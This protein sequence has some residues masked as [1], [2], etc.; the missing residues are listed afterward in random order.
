MSDPKLISPMLDNFDMGAP[1]TDRMGIRCCPAMKKDADDKY[2]VKI[3][4]IPAS[5]VQLDALLLTGA[6]ADEASAQ[7]Y[8]KELSDTVAEEVRILN[9]LSQ[10]EGFLPYEDT[11]TVP[12]DDQTGYDVYLL[13]TYKRSLEKHFRRSPMTHLGALNLG[14]DLCAALTVCRK[15]GYLYVDLKPGNIYLTADNSYSIGDLGFVDLNSLKYASLPDK[16]R[17]QYTAPEVQD[18]FSSLNTTIDI[19][20]AGLI[21]YQAFNDGVLPFCGETA[22]CEEF[23][24]P[25]YADYEMSEIILK[26]CAPDP[27]DRWQDPVEMG[28]ALVSY[29]QR[30]GA[31]DTPIVPVPAAEDTYTD[32]AAYT[33]VAE[34]TVSDESTA[35]QEDSILVESIAPQEQTPEETEDASDADMISAEASP[36]AED[37]FGNLTFLEDASDDETAPEN[38]AS[39]MDYTEVTEEVSEILSVADELIS[40]PAP[41]PVVAPDPIDVPV[42]PPLPIDQEPEVVEDTTEEQEEAS[43]ADCANEKVST[44]D[45]AESEEDPEDI[46]LP[47]KSSH[48]WI[49][50]IAVILLALSLLSACVY[51]YQNFY[52]QPIT[53]ALEGS[54]SNL[55]V[56]VSSKIDESKLLVICSDIYGN[57]LQAPVENGK[58][59]FTDLVPNSVYTVNVVIKGFHR[60][61]GDTSTAYSTPVQTNIVQFDAVTGT[62]DGSIILRFTID[63]PDSDR[64]K[65]TYTSADAAA[66]EVIFSGHMVTLN[67]LSIGT[68]YTFTLEPEDDLYITGKNQVSFTAQKLVSAQSLQITDYS[69]QSLTITWSAPE[70]VTVNRWFVRCYNDKG[71]DKTI[72]TAELTASFAEID[73]DGSYTVEVTAEGMSVG[74]RLLLSEGTVIVTNMKAEAADPNT[75]TVTWNASPIA[76]E[77]GWIVLYSINGSGSQQVINTAENTAQISPVI[78]GATYSIQLQAAN[79]SPVLGGAF[80]YVA[81]ASQDFSGYG[82]DS[83][84]IKFDMCK[85]PSVANWTVYNLSRSDYTTTFTVGQKASFLAST[86]YAY[87]ESDDIIVTLFVITDQGGNIISATSQSGAWS[88]MWRRGYCELDIPEMPK[89]AGSYTISIYFNGTLANRQDF[90]VTG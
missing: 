18:A 44:S 40:H 85:T 39:E 50:W 58:A 25:A 70:G 6:Y 55:T 20:A 11:Q 17:S 41:D 32:D 8:F 27:A 73:Q 15:S 2:I 62:E 9:R 22:P 82:I 48:R 89:E 28:Q 24:P 71:Y 36:Y 79:G 67:G 75:L 34:E 10:L 77:G 86:P 64:W 74:Q 60:L 35:V 37:D 21:L 56:T 3:I 14:L 12:M 54:E 5:R 63:G 4:S 49:R 68:A 26:A 72:E 1:I 69:N 61:T 13:S 84:H 76:P 57:Q 88:S 43:D 7:A 59:V 19:Y 81:P 66:Q 83:A 47:R 90:T 29:M 16:Y 42:P 80:T 38:G 87:K 51:Y 53:M 33:E 65:V 31:N 78:P 45:D 52:I 23:A 46:Y 30:N